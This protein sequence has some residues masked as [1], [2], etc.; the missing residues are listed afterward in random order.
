MRLD[1][2][3]HEPFGLAIEV[4]TQLL[5]EVGLAPAAKEHRAEPGDDDVPDAHE[6]TSAAARG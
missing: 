1:S 5:A 2:R 4:E 3:G 6:P